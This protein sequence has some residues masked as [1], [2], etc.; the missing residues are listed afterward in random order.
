VLPGTRVLAAVIVPFLVLAFAVLFPVPTDTRHLFAW[1]I[2]PTM[3]PMVLGAVYL[4][5]AYFFARVVPAGQWH[6]VA[7]GFP[8]VAVFAGLMGITTVLHWDRFLHDNVAFWL[9]VA[10]YF[11]T[12]VLVLA[13]FLVNQREYL[14]AGPDDL[15]LSPLAAGAVV[16]VGSAS[17]VTGAFLY[18]FPARAIA[19]WPWHLTTLTARM[20]GAI[21]ALGLAGLGAIRERRWS[22]ARLLLQVAGLMLALIFA[23]G[24]RAR[25]EFD[26]GRALT[27]ILLV[28]FAG[29]ALAGAGLYVRMETRR[30]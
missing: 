1:Q 25:A 22:A 2:R 9:W 5:G 28:G 3:S 30:E 27:W 11:T 19:I 12:P 7:G 16:A 26:T 15:V 17:V 24:I 18:L 29:T 23:A 8:P 14:P 20:L 6:T 4:G 13:T 10:L 21:F